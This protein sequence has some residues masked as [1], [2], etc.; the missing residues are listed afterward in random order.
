MWQ[1]LHTCLILHQTT[2]SNI[3]HI[4]YLHWFIHFVTIIIHVRVST[5]ILREGRQ[6]VAYWVSS[7]RDRLE[8][9]KLFG[10]K[11]WEKLEPVRTYTFILY[12]YS[13]SVSSA[14][15][16]LVPIPSHTGWRAYKL[17]FDARCPCPACMPISVCCASVFGT[18]HA[19]TY[20]CIRYIYN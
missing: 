7:K 11:N 3:C 6:Q 1:A 8:L 4:F 13:P 15:T 14:H 12:R 10:S 18:R 16:S 17:N 20:I 2:T 9:A 19:S 5:E